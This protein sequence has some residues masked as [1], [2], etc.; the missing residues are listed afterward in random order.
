VVDAE[1]HNHGLLGLQGLAL[2]LSLGLVKKTLLLCSLILR[3]VLQQQLE[4]AGGWK[5]SE[6]S[7][8]HLVLHLSHIN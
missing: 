7:R 5:R 8:I 2:G 4:Q 1:F 6:Q 3:S